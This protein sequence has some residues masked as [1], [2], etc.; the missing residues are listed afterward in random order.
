MPA[1][2]GNYLDT[3]TTYPSGTYNGSTCSAS[4]IIE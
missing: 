4:C 2:I 3:S 1:T